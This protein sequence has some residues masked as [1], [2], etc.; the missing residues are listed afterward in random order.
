MNHSNTFSAADA[1]NRFGELLDAARRE[2]VVIKK[3]GRSVAVMLSSEEY[4]R[5]EAL[6]DAWWGAQAQK[7]MKEP[8]IGEHATRKLLAEMLHA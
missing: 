7:A 1:K 6:D 4:R 5:L 2:P 3:H 8:S